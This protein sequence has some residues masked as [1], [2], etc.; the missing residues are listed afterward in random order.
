MWLA[1][2][3]SST[4]HCGAHSTPHHIPV[5]HGIWNRPSLDLYTH[6][7]H[8]FRRID[9]TQG[10]VYTSA[11]SSALVNADAGTSAAIQPRMQR[12][13]CPDTVVCLYY[14]L[15]NTHLAFT[16]HTEV[17]EADSIGARLLSACL[18]TLKVCQPSQCIDILTRAARKHGGQVG[19]YTGR[20]GTCIWAGIF[21]HHHPAHP[22]RPASPNT[23]TTQCTAGTA[24]RAA[25][26]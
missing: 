12:K 10:H 19:N 16:H 17:S 20:D 6:A 1:P 11:A 4:H 25:P 2:P 9:S 21:L 24:A 22:H 5:L 7:R 23:G 18:R 3:R 8:A 14:P 26:G 13:Q 15:Y